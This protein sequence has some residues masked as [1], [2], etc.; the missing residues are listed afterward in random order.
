MIDPQIEN[1]E[2]SAPVEPELEEWLA[3]GAEP[4]DLTTELSRRKFL[5]G[6]VA[7]GAAGLA[8]AAGTG[9]A[10]WQIGDAQRQRMQAD[11]EAEIARLQGLLDLYENLEKIGLDAILAS[12][13]KAL[14]LPLA[15]IE[16]GARALKGGLDWA[17]GALLSLQEAL[18]TAEE[19]LLW[20]ENQVLDLADGVRKLEE[21]IGHALGRAVDNRVAE[22]LSEFAGMVLDYLPFGVGDKIRQV[23]DE[24][25][26]LVTGID[27]LILRTNSTVLTPLRQKWF[28]SEGKEGLSAAV[29]SP[30]VQKVLDPLELHLG[31][32][33]ALGDTW[34][35]EFLAP[36]D[37]ALAERETIRKQI[38]QYK[39]E[40]HLI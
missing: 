20:L 16:A 28:S 11:A 1:H 17:E 19:S 4:S 25:T 7:G 33:A 18:P 3:Q 26:R 14:A 5:T 27:D 37:Q 32:L 21:A 36:T 15:A 34:Q 40:H 6:A 13:I 10:V 31:D 8:V 23:L 22:L 38:S 29:I 24:I 30:L 9:V 35:Q 39:E 2:P 12:G